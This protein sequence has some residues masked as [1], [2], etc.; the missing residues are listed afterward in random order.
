MLGVLTIHHVGQ[1]LMN[2]LASHLGTYLAL[3]IISVSAPHHVMHL[4]YLG[5]VHLV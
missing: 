5:L 2:G 4:R 3:P 1:R